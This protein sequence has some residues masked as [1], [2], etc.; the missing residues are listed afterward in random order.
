MSSAPALLFAAHDVSLS[1]AWARGH[2]DQQRH[3]RHQ[4]WIPR[5]LG[6]RAEEQSESTKISLLKHA[7]TTSKAEDPPSDPIT[8]LSHIFSNTMDRLWIGS[9][10]PRQKREAVNSRRVA[11]DP[12]A[13]TW[14]RGHVHM[15]TRP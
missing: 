7:E 2:V 15:S 12:V 11:S 5:P 10:N 14:H 9:I 8:H 3:H 6:Y 4:V 1:S 13:S